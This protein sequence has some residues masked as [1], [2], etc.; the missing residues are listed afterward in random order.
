[1][2]RKKIIVIDAI[3]MSFFSYLYIS[4]LP[5]DPTLFQKVV[6]TAIVFMAVMFLMRFPLVGKVL[7]FW[8]TIVWVMV[9]M[10]I[11]PFGDLTND[12]PFLMAGIVVVLFLIFLSL[13]DI[14]IQNVY[15]FFKKSKKK[16]I[17][18]ENKSSLF[19]ESRR[20]PKQENVRNVSEE[21]VLE[22]G[23]ERLY[24]LIGL[25]EVKNEISSIV[26]FFAVQKQRK[27]KKLK[28][29]PISMHLV[30]SGNPGTGKTEVARILGSIYKDIGALE[31]GHV[32]E[33]SRS[34]LVGEHIGETGIKTKK[35]IEKAYGGVLFIDEAYTLLG[36]KN[37]FGQEAIDCLLLEM[38]NNRD[39]LV[40]I[41]AGY[42]DLMKKFISS[43]PGLES[44][45]TRTIN[46]SDYSANE[47]F[48]IFKK[49]CADNDY[50]LDG[51]ASDLMEEKL[52]ILVR[53]KDDNFGNAR[54]VRK[55]YEQII[56]NQ[57]GRIASQ[58]KVSSDELVT[59]IAKDIVEL[60]Y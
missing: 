21:V 1:M 11:V 38:E 9:L 31:K 18:V 60:N 39:N 37:D 17:V 27:A 48:Q 4:Q 34:D 56:R 30:F 44:R 33:V 46:F 15:R 13:H 58:G 54:T 59:I 25:E 16:K 24:S 42:P 45:F 2:E 23:F 19:V 26:D 55:L 29:Q 41:I 51:M 32:I 35:V 52:E 43:N 8:A 47:L 50:V 22:N 7:Q 28:T 49:Y 3:I 6:F 36:E 57:S 40:V 10:V 14:N 5:T 12:N 53:N 20:T